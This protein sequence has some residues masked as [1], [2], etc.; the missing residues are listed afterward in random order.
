MKIAVDNNQ[1]Q[2]VNQAGE[3]MSITKQFQNV[4][5]ISDSILNLSRTIEDSEQ[6]INRVPKRKELLPESSI[7]RAMEVI[8]EEIQKELP[9]QRND[10]KEAESKYNQEISNI[11]QKLADI[12]EINE[13]KFAFILDGGDWYNRTTGKSSNVMPD[14]VAE[15]LGDEAAQLYEYYINRDGIYYSAFGA[16]K[17]IQQSY[18]QRASFDDAPNIDGRVLRNAMEHID[19]LER[20]LDF[21]AELETMINNKTAMNLLRFI[22]KQDT[23]NNIE[24]YSEYPPF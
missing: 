23:T 6:L 15:L 4:I 8:A 3:K 24:N 10:L 16:L 9:K 7:T 1:N 18:S 19:Y 13:E 5:E 20:S 2:S 17:S 22:S 14:Q 12:C 11:I 21:E